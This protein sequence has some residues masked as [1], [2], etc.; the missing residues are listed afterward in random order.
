[1]TQTRTEKTTALPYRA[2]P[3][4]PWQVTPTPPKR[5]QQLVY[6]AG[7][8]RVAARERPLTETVGVALRDFYQEVLTEPLPPELARLVHALRAR[9]G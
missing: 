1:M 4:M 5:Q 7:K 9:I 3:H 2:P 8:A 6:H